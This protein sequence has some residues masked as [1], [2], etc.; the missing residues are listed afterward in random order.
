MTGGRLTRNVSDFTTAYAR[1]RRD[2]GCRYTLGFYDTKPE[3]NK[4]HALRVESARDGVHLQYAD[5]YSFPSVAER[6]AQA[7]QAAY[8]APQMFEGGGMR[9]HVF[10]VEPKDGKSWEAIIAIDFPL[11]AE[12]AAEGAAQREFGVVLQRGS[13][14][15]HTFHRSLTLSGEGASRDRR[16][17]FLEPATLQPG[18]YVIHAVL[19]KPS[20]DKPFAAQVEVVVPEIPKKR[21]FLVGPLLGRRSGDDVVVFGGTT[22]RVGAKTAFR[23]LLVGEVDRKLPLAAL[24]QA[25]VVKPK[26]GEGPWI[27][28]RALLSETGDPLAAMPGIQLEQERKTDVVCREV[29]DELP[30]ETL[31]IGRYT[32]QATLAGVDASLLDD[33]TRKVPIAL[34]GETP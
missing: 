6:R 21:P 33:G 14:V 12:V 30:L 28:E 24:T 31:P 32:F 3:E 25:C 26:R 17:T 11:G 23:P 22:D 4:Q 10:P 9:A 5:R 27:A 15:A 13:E 34:V 19:A 2:L 20:D 29:F 8:L 16:I 18:R 7:V 1:A